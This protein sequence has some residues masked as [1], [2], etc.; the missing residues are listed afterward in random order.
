LPL[1]FERLVMTESRNTWT[2]AVCR[3]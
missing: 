3:K 2:Y 1:Q